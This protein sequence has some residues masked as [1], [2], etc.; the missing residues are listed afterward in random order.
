MSLSVKQ[1]PSINRSECFDRQ[2][3]KGK[4]PRNRQQ[5]SPRKVQERVDLESRKVIISQSRWPLGLLVHIVPVLAA[6]TIITINFR[7]Y[8]IGTQFAGVTNSA[9]QSIVLSSLQVTAKLFVGVQ[10]V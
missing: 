10:L 6:I 7:G 8:F 3:F 1:P 4:P 9:S 2:R 5:A